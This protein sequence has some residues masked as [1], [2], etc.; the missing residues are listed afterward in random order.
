MDYV[1]EYMLNYL[2]VK[3]HYVCNLLSNGLEGEKKV[4]T[5]SEFRQRL[6]VDLLFLHILCI[7]NSSIILLFPFIVN[8]K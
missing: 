7:F 3:C 8:L 4:L 6:Y 1:S 2:A 5:S